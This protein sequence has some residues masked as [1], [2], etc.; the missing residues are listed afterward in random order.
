M[1]QI[2]SKASANVLA[3]VKVQSCA[4]GRLFLSNIY[5]AGFVASRLDRDQPRAAIE[6]FALATLL[7]QAAGH[8]SANSSKSI[9]LSYHAA[10]P[11]AANDSELIGA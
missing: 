1:A 5:G 7:D 8:K 3:W 10:W 11:N 2:S 4:S 9:A 6:T